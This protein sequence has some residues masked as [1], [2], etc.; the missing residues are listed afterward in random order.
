M[1]AANEKDG[2][3]RSGAGH[4]CAQKYDGLIRDARASQLRVARHHR[5]CDHQGQPDRY[6]R[7]QHG[8]RAAVNHQQDDEHQ[9]GDSQLDRKPVPITRDGE[10]GDGC[11]GP[12]E[13]C[14]QGRSG[15]GVFDDVADL[16]ESGV[17]PWSAQLARNA[18]RQHP[19]F[20]VRAGHDRSQGRCADEI[21]QHHDISRVVPQRVHQ[22]AVNGFIGGAEPFVVGQDHQQEVFRARF[23][24]RLSHL[25]SGDVRRCVAGQDRERMLLGHLVEGWGCQCQSNRY[26]GPERYDYQG[27]PDYKIG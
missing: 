25:S 2:V 13:V 19:S 5:L 24:K 15:D 18:D 12:G 8:D 17:R 4:D 6:Q 9:N 3:I 20:V 7:Q 11:S 14:R 16:V 10:V 22:V 23:V 26:R 1:I 21:L 27:P